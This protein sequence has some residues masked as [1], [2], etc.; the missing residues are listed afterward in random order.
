MLTMMIPGSVVL[1]LLM[2]STEKCSILLRQDVGTSRSMNL[3][4]HESLPM[5]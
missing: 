5:R 2:R 3:Y 1:I 4:L